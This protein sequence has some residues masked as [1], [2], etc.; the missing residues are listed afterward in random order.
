MTKMTEKEAFGCGALIVIAV[1]SLV[2]LL[3]G[4]GIGLWVR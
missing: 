3:V 4:V 1:A 2:S